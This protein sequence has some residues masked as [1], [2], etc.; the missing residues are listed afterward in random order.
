MAAEKKSD[1]EID[2][3]KSFAIMKKEFVLV[4]IIVVLI[5]LYAIYSIYFAWV[6]RP[7]AYGDSSIGMTPE[8]LAAWELYNKQLA[9]GVK[10]T[11]PELVTAWENTNCTGD[12][13]SVRPG[14]YSYKKKGGYKNLPFPN[15]EVRCLQV[16]AG[17]TVYATDNDSF[18]PGNHGSKKII[19]PSN[20]AFLGNLAGKVSSIAVWNS[21]DSPPTF[22]S[23]LS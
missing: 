16:P 8:E 1:N 7:T 23:V 13:W 22:Y 20:S 18:E 17:L 15:D 14:L 4:A 3:A 19:G 6:T 21:K 12:K 11:A 9:A 5:L 10:S 2:F